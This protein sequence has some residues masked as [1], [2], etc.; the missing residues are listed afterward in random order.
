[1]EAGGA[2]RAVNHGRFQVV[3]NH[4]SRAAAK[5]LEGIDQPAVEFRLRARA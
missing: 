5:E 3:D 1:M 2:A 4:G